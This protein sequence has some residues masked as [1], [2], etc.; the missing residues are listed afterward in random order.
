MVANQWF[1]QQQR[2]DLSLVFFDASEKF[3]RFLQMQHCVFWVPDFNFELGQVLQGDAQ[4]E[5]IKV[6]LLGVVSDASFAL[7]QKLDQLGN[8]W[9]CLYSVED[10]ELTADLLIVIEDLGI[11]IGN[12]VRVFV[13]LENVFQ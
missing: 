11:K 6:N 8:V 1:S 12:L 4:S 5:V 2:G 7:V 9:Q 13:L 10:G 3:L